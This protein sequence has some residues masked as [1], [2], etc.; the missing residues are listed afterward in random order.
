VESA[1]TLPLSV[2][3]VLGTLQLFLMLQGRILAEHAAFRAT[4]AGSVRHGECEAMMDAA[5]LAVLPSIESFLGNGRGGSPARKLAEAFRE[6]KDRNYRYV[7]GVDGAHGAQGGGDIIWIIRPSPQGGTFGT[8]AQLFD[9]PGGGL[10]LETRL[11]FWFPLKIPFAD[12]VIS[13]MLLA[14]WGWGIGANPNGSY[15]AVNPLMATQTANWTQERPPT[16]EAS[17]RDEMVQR[18]I[19]RKQYVFPIHASGSL[20]MMTPPRQEFFDRQNCN[21]APPALQ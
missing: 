9:Q 20:R 19:E 5:L 11:I 21:P 10:R 6:R 7:D 15:T 1:L 4:R 17:I 18:V 14:R 13:R 12:W 8:E 2:F 3:L 16:L